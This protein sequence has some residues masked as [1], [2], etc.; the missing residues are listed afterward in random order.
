MNELTRC[1]REAGRP[2]EAAALFERA[3]EIEEAKL[4]TDN[5]QV[6]S[7]LDALRLCVREAAGTGEAVATFG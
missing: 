1:V 6:A 5:P 3:L 7:M 2:G 4:R